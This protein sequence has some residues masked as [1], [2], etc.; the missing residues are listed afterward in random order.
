MENNLSIMLYKWRWMTSLLVLIP[1]YFLYTGQQYLGVAADYKVWF[2]DKNPELSDFV[3]IQK[4]Y[5]KSD[6]VIFL[7]EAK[8]GEIFS[9]DILH[10]LEWLTKEAWK[11]PYSIRVESITNYQ[12]TF[13]NGNELIVQDLI[14]N[15]Q[16]YD[17]ATIAAKKNIALNDPMLNKRFISNNSAVTSVNVT[18]DLPEGSV[19][20]N[21]KVA[22]YARDLAKQLEEKNSSLTVRLSGL[23]MMDNALMEA[24]QR[25]MQT[26][27]NWLYAVI[28]IG[29]ILFLRSL[30]AT[31][32]VVVVLFLSTNA[33][34]GFAGW[35]G[36]KLTPPSAGSTTIVMTLVV[37][38]AVH[39]ITT[40]F[41]SMRSGNT[42]E[43]GIIASLRLNMLPIL[44]TT[45]CTIVGF[46]SMHLLE[47]PPF[48]DLGNMVAMGV[49]CALV[50]SFT[51][52]PALLSVAPFKVKTV[53]EKNMNIIKR[54]G[55]FIVSNSGKVAL[56]TGIVSIGLILCIPLNSINDRI[57]EYFDESV[58]FRQSTDYAVQYL[59][60]PYYLEYSLKTDTPGG[61]SNPEYFSALEKF[62]AWLK[63]QDEVLHVQSMAHTLKKL[64]M[65]LNGGGSEDYQVPDNTKAISQ[66]LLLYE[67]SLPYGLDL[68]N[69]IDFNKSASK[70]LVS[71]TNL[72]NADYFAFYNKVNDWLIENVPE[73][74][75]VAGSPTFMFANIGKRAVMQMTTG[76][77]IGLLIMSVIVMI[78]LRSFK[79]GLISLIPNFLPPLLA[80]G[81]WGI[82][83]GEIGFAMVLGVGMTIGIIVDDTIHLLSKYLRAR[84]EQGMSVENAVL[85]AYNKVARALVITSIALSSG[86]FLLTFSTFKINSDMGFITVIVIGIALLL[87]LILL[88]LV[89]L[90][91]D[92]SDQP[93]K[94]KKSGHNKNFK[95]L[96]EV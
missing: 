54:S 21:P 51:V 32:C 22:A 36:V 18:I 47:V 83:W 76:I 90:R 16:T 67:L 31:L 55:D 27:S 1:I 81:V 52:L 42:K 24:A 26:L 72:S 8:D 61:I 46:M 3:E 13:A 75:A 29:L 74:T 33:T 79:L 69:Q 64:N 58:D 88:P 10:D 77:V 23:I 14:R 60:G 56:A 66:Y 53:H 91:F 41:D 70:V 82:I 73:Y 96:E 19:D 45:L 39:L 2:V 62:D 49:L 35:M 37:A 63:Q 92:R 68:N 7:I 25:D 17:A 50:L 86:F 85:F 48:H 71:L 87:D 30:T 5:N 43:L 59:T 93:Y 6:N 11:V 57:W 20:G 38:N 12:H 94:K 95:I 44:L 80:F 34:M 89:L 40:M 9:A 65:N 84:R 28:I 78:V 15:S 4:T